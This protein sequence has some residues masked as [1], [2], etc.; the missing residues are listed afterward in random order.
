MAHEAQ[1]NFCLRVKER[2]PEA[3]RGG[4]VLDVGSLDVNGNNRYL[5]EG[6]SY[7]GLDVGPGPNVDVV[8]PVH[9]VEMFSPES[10]SVVVSTECFEHDMHFAH[11]LRKIVSL[12]RPGG[13][14]FFT[15]AG[16]G[17]PEHGTTR[18]CPGDSPLTVAI[19]DWSDFYKNV[20]RQDVECALDLDRTFEAWDFESSPGDIYFWGIKRSRSEGAP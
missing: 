15:A 16:E 19:P 20:T 3:F 7:I 14:F 5:F 6:S 17:R 2:F 10:F 12:L 13:L 18:S 11:S 9:L 4:T 8:A 1:K